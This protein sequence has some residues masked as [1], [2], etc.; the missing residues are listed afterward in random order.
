MGFE[1][2]RDVPGVLASLRSRACDSS[3]SNP[4]CRSFASLRSAELTGTM[5]FEPTTIGLEVRRSVQAE[6]R[7]RGAR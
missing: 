7:A 1:P 5:G 4:T 3:T 6:L 2:R